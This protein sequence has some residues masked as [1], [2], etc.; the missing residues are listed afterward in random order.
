MKRAYELTDFGEFSR[1]VQK[2]EGRVSSFCFLISVNAYRG[3]KPTFQKYNP[4]FIEMIQ[5]ETIYA[6][7]SRNSREQNHQ[8]KPVA[9]ARIFTPKELKSS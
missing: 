5:P 2:H 6:I 7:L 1:A 3:L 8:I 9:A 4:L